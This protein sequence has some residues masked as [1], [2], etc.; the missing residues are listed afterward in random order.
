MNH[1]DGWNG[2]KYQQ[3]EPETGERNNIAGRDVMMA[4]SIYSLSNLFRIYLLRRYIHIFL[5][6]EME[7]RSHHRPYE[8][9]K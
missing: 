1:D 2:I 4:V 8:S 6:E 7:E 5:G 3:G 9:Y